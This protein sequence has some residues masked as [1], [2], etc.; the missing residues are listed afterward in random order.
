MIKSMTGYGKAEVGLA[1]GKLTVEIRTLNGK[2][3]DVAIK[4]NLLPKELEMS[5]RRRIAEVLVR[6]T[7]DVYLN[8]EPASQEGRLPLDTDLLKEYYKKVSAIGEELKADSELLSAILRFPDVVSSGAAKKADS[9]TEADTAAVN[10]VIEEALAAVDAYRCIEGKALYQDVTSRVAKIQAIYDEIEILDK[11]RKDLVREKLTKAVE[12]LQ[13]KVDPSRFE[14]EMIFY[15]EKLD[16]NEE[17]VRLRQ[18]S[19]YF[20]ETIDGEPY[21]GKKLGFIIQEMG[22]EINTTGSKANYAP[23]QKLV[24]KAKDQLEKIREQSMN[25]L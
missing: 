6:G 11:E 23:I 22:R 7:I 13:V 25:I 9:I 19:H 15:L 20:M 3:A 8:F 21:P 10:K 24:V 14:Q 16:I 5:L 18:H 4:S 17:K 12:D 2:S 1:G